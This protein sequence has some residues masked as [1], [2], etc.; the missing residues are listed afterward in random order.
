VPSRARAALLSLHFSF[1]EGFYLYRKYGAGST[2]N[3]RTIF[4]LAFGGMVGEIGVSIQQGGA[5]AGE[6]LQLHLLLQQE[7]ASTEKRFLKLF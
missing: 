6:S 5:I 3:T 7:R 2:Q 4:E 1:Y